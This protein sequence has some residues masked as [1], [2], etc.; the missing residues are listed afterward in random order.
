MAKKSKKTKKPSIQDWV[1]QGILSSTEGLEIKYFS[2]QT[3]GKIFF[4]EF[5]TSL[6]K[7]SLKSFLWNDH[8]NKEACRVIIKELRKRRGVNILEIIEYFENSSGEIKKDCTDWLY[9]RLSRAKTET[10]LRLYI[11]EKLSYPAKEIVAL[12]LLQKSGGLV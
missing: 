2:A 10:L 7:A 12:S 5:L 6:D 1:N 11:M 3:N 9:D 8:E 4:E